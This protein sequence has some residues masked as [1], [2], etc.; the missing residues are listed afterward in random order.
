MKATLVVCTVVIMA[1][2]LAL[3]WALVLPKTV[4]VTRTMLDFR[5]REMLAA[6]V[7]FMAPG[8]TLYCYGS[9]WELVPFAYKVGVNPR[10]TQLEM[11]LAQAHAEADTLEAVID[12]LEH[13]NWEAD[14]PDSNAGPIVPWPSAPL[15]MLKEGD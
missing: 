1:A 15:A 2:I 7:E 9:G 4:I 8:D 14:K 5:S 11:A 6:T 10:I 3:T 12:S 13:D